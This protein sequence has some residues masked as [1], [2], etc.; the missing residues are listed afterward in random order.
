MLGGLML[1]VPSFAEFSYYGL[2]GVFNLATKGYDQLK[3]KA[4]IRN[5]QTDLATQFARQNFIEA[6]KKPVLSQEEHALSSEISEAAIVSTTPDIATYFVDPSVADQSISDSF[7]RN[8]GS[9][10][11]LLD[12]AWDASLDPTLREY[13]S[14]QQNLETHTMSLNEMVNSASDSNENSFEKL[15]NEYRQRGIE[16]VMIVVKGESMDPRFGPETKVPVRL[17]PPNTEY[18]EGDIIAF[19]RGDIYTFHEVV[20]SYVF[21][22]KTYYV[23]GGLNPDTNQYVDSFTIP[24]DKILGYAEISENSLSGTQTLEQQGVLIYVPAH[25]STNQFDL[26]YEA[27]IESQ[28]GIRNWMEKANAK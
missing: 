18:K 25:A 10:G 26:L 8:E 21:N 9:S 20:D 17:M 27:L 15:I 11:V 6:L 3:Q 2:K 12:F 1:F 28:Q 23:T 14:E 5:F 7:S 13:M 22:G 4:L 19:K 16:W 24:A